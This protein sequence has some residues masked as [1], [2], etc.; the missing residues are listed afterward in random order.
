MSGEAAPLAPGVVK[1]PVS[2]D[3]TCAP[4][5]A[6]NSRVAKDTVTPYQ[7]VVTRLAN[8]WIVTT[9]VVPA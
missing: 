3:E 6:N 9:F 5:L 2:A 4:G 1:D 8:P 7:V